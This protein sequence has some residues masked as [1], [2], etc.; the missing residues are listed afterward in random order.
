MPDIRLKNQ[1]FDLVFSPVHDQVYVGLLTGEVKGFTYDAD[2]E[3]ARAFTLRPTKRSCR[4][5]AINDA[6]SRLYSVSKDK[7]LQCVQP[8]HLASHANTH[9]ACTA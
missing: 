1:C 8:R 2:G 3:A 6:G 9:P 5:L 4:G 7:S